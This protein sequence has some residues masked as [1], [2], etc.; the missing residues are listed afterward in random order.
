MVKEIEE[1]VPLACGHE[2]NA[3]RAWPKRW[4]ALKNYL[5]EAKKE[6]EKLI[7]K[8]HISKLATYIPKKEDNEGNTIEK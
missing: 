3:K 1:V 8:L 4:G 6:E 7:F 2:S 5:R